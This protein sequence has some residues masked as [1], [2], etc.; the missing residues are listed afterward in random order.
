MVSN[1]PKLREKTG[2]GELDAGKAEPRSHSLGCKGE[3]TGV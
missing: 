2:D 3:D 1:S